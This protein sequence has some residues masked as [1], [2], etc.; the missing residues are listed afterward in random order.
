MTI[1]LH[2]YI[3]DSEMFILSMS[4]KEGQYYQC[5]HDHCCAFMSILDEPQ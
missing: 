3:N 4:P 2:F 5:D 1:S